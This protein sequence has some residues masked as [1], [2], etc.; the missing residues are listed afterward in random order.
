[1]SDEITGLFYADSEEELAFMMLLV[2]YMALYTYGPDVE[3]ISFDII[4][5]VSD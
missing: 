5:L 2:T 4:T 1:M 3:K